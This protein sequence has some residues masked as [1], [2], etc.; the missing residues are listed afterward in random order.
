M[1]NLE[2]PTPA[3]S[4]V[5]REPK[6]EDAPGVHALV[7]ASKPLDLNSPYAY[8]L[9]CTHFRDTCVVIEHQGA[10]CGFVSGYRKPADPAVLFVWQVAVGPEVRGRGVGKQLLRALLARPACSGV[11]HV[12][13]TITPSNRAS[14]ALFAWLAREYHAPCARSTAFRAGDFGAT[15][16]E[17]EELLRIGPLKAHPRNAI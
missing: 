15:G 10:V 13:T 7:E 1:T 9:L 12:E 16:H 6:L 2:T 8:L 14:H 4:V 5:C 17:E 11:T 3:V